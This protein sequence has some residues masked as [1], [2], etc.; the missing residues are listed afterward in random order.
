MKKLIIDNGLEFCNQRFDNYCVDEGILRHITVRLT[1][2]QNSLAEMMNKTLMERV[3]CKLVQTKLLKALWAEI[4]LTTYYLV[5]LSLSSAIDFKRPHEKW[6][7]QPTNYG[8]LKA[9]GCSAYAHIS[10]GKLAPRALKSIF[11]RY[12]ERVKGYKIYC[13]YVNPPKGIISRDVIFNDEELISK[14]FV[15]R[16]CKDDSKGS[17]RH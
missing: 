14:K 6:T 2:Q 16:M 9:F 13:K 8:N 17:D 11:I 5:N 15:Q 1:P 12:L 3:R 4:L 10:Q 7:G